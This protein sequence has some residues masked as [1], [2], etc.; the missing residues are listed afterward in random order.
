MKN[1]VMQGTPTDNRVPFL[2]KYDVILWG[3]LFFIVGTVIR[4]ALRD[5]TS[6]DTDEFLV[7]WYHEIQYGGGLQYLGHQV[8]DYNILY[9]TLIALF[10]YC[11]L[12]PLYAYKLFSCCF[13]VLLAGLAAYIVYRA[14]EQS[15]RYKALAAFGLV[16]LSPVVFINAAW[17]GQCDAIYT[18]FGIAALYF[19]SREKDFTAFILYGVSMTF[20]LQ[21]IFLMPMMLFSVFCRKKWHLVYVL[22]IPAVMV[23]LSMGGLLAGRQISDVFTIYLHQTASYPSVA[24]NYPSVW[25]LLSDTGHIINYAAGTEVLSS[26]TLYNVVKYPAILIAVGVLAA[27]MFLWRRKGVTFTLKH[28]LIMAFILAY[29]CVILLPSMHERYGY[30]YEILSLILVLLYPK[31]TVKVIILHGVTLCTYIHFLSNC[32]FVPIAVLS[33]INIVLYVLMVR[34]LCRELIK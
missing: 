28:T 14:A 20:K 25:G 30:V 24:L 7:P 15:G 23:L 11:P 2:K 4:F 19:L 10:T 16:Y 18:F 27:Y 17:W 29:T 34:F 22:M 8:G 5:L 13:D 31:L 26:E 3:C 1:E 32:Y 21:A 33:V 12:K 6:I 9:Q